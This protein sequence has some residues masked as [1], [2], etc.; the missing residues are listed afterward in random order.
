MPVRPL[1]SP[2]AKAMPPYPIPLAIFFG[3][4]CFFSPSVED[5]PVSVLPA[6]EIATDILLMYYFG[7]AF[8]WT[9]F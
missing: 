3:F 9:A 5:Y 8:Y 4:L 7:C 1:N 6:L 2:L